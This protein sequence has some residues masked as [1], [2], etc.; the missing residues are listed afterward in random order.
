MRE[1]RRELGEVLEV[2]EG[3]EAAAVGEAP[4]VGVAAVVR[5]AKVVLELLARLEASG[6]VLPAGAWHSALLACRKRER[7]SEVLSLLERMGAQADT[8]AHNEVL[9]TLRLK[10]DYEAACTVWRGL[11]A[12]GAAGGDGR[13][14]GGRGAAGGARVGMRP[15]PARPT[16]RAPCA[17]A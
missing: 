4:Q 16:P 6:T 1:Q 13:Y 9:H 5:V 12:R 3:D 2:R 7:K 11:R 15:P 8:L 14:S 17:S 10:N